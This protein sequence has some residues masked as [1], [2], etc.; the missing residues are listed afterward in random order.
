MITHRINS[1][2]DKVNVCS[3]IQG[4]NLEAKET[5]QVTID[6]YKCKRTI[7]QNNLWHRQ[8]RELA[9]VMNY[10]PAEM[11]S[12]VKYALGY[13]HE[14]EGK[15]N[16]V[17]VFDETSGMNVEQLSTLIEQT[18]TWAAEKGVYLE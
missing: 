12:I 2:Q 9:R 7:E 17:M 16:K 11:K 14:I 10:T 1:E 13:Y 8:V 3:I 6:E 15:K 4:I 18:Y 5:M